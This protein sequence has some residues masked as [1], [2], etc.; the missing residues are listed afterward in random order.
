ML[1]VARSIAGRTPAGAR[2]YVEKLLSSGAVKVTVTVAKVLRVFLDDPDAPCYGLELMRATGL[3]SG[4]LYPVLARLERAGW[5]RSEREEIDPAAEGRP[6]RRYYELTPDGLA[7]ARSELAAL[8][9]RFR[10][11]PQVPRGLPQPNGGPA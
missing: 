11:P 3:P 5:V 9:E 6:A 2:P 4:S 7:T 8:A 1:P 10:P